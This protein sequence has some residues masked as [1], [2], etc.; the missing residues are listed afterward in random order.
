MRQIPDKLYNT[1]TLEDW[2]EALVAHPRFER[3]KDVSL[4]SLPPEWLFGHPIA[5][6]WDHSLGVYHLAHL[7]HPEDVRRC[8]AALLHDI[9][10][11][12]FSNCIE[13]LMVEMLGS[14]HEERI[15]S[16]VDELA[17]VVPAGAIEW[18]RV[19][20]LVCGTDAAESLVN[21]T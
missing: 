7:C 17:A 4:S 16:Y 8:A 15:N 10:Q 3:L 13:H 14:D 5:T 20:A 11:P 18:R 6:R 1:I 9:R 19:G 2:A 21:G 12:P